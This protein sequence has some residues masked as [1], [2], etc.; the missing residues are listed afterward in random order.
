MHTIY[1]DLIAIVPHWDFLPKFLC[2]SPNLP[3]LNI[4]LFCSDVQ[5]NKRFRAGKFGGKDRNQ[6]TITIYSGVSNGVHILN[7]FS[8]SAD[9]VY[10]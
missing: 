1:N 4:K 2:F 3:E 8:Y 7:I 6:Q 5:N 9:A 10:L